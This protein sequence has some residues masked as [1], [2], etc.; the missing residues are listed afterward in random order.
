[1]SPGIKIVALEKATLLGSPL[2]DEGISG[3]IGDKEEALQ[4][5]KE[6][7]THIGTDNSLYSVLY[8]LKNYFLLGCCFT[9]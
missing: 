5:L 6:N 7:L 8:I 1:M 3:I 2:V 9:L 4:R